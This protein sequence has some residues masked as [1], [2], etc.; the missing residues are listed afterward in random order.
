MSRARSNDSVIPVDVGEAT[1]GV[2]DWDSGQMMTML[3]RC[4]QKLT[5]NEAVKSI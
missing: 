2:G 4:M 1:T 5:T 3:T